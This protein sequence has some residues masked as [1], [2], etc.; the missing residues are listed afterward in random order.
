MKKITFIF[1]LLFLATIGYSQNNQKVLAAPMP[2]AAP[3]PGGGGDR[4]V[5]WYRDSDK[6]GFGDPIRTRLSATKIDGYVAEGD[7]LD[8]TNKYITNVAP[9]QYFYHDSD[10]D[11][12]GNPNVRVFYSIAPPNYVTNNLDC[13]DN[14]AAIKPTTVWYR[15]G[16]HDGYGNRSITIIGCIQ[17]ADYVINPWDYDDANGAITNITPQTF[18]RDYDTDTFGSP[19]VTVY[20]SVKPDGYVTNN[21]DCND[22]NV[23]INPN[24]VW[25]RDVDGDNFGVREITVLS[26]TRP[27]GYTDNGDDCNDSDY[28]LNPN[29]VWYIDSDHDTFGAGAGSRFGC[30][31]PLN[32]DYVLKGGDCND[33][34][35]NV[36]PDVMWY[37]DVD[38]DG[39]GVTNN[40]VKSCTQPVGYARESG[41]CDDGNR[42]IKPNTIWYFDN[43]G[44]GHGAASQTKQSCT[45]PDRYVDTADDCNDYDV[46]VYTV[47]VWYY[48]NDGDTFGDPAVTVSSCNKPYKYVL[49][50]AD[51]DDRTGNITNIPPRTFYEDYDKDTFGNPNVSVYY[52]NQPTGYVT[53]ASDYDDRTGNIIN[54]QP[55]NFYEDYDKDTFGNPNVSLYYSLQPTGYVTNASDYNDRN[56]FITNIPPQTF[57]KDFDKDTFGNPNITLYYSIQPTGYVANNTDCDD[58]NGDLNPNTK[59]Y[60]DNEQDGLG[61][62]S[63]FVQ[64]CTPPAGKYVANYSDNCPTIAGTSPDC[65]SLASP[66]SDYNYI[67]TTTYKEPTNTILQGPTPEKALVNITYFDG[68]GRPVQQIANKQSTAGKDIITSTGYDDFGRPTKEYLPYAANSSNMAY[69]AN[70][71]ENA[72]TFYSAEKYENTANPFSEKK[73]ELSP[74]GRVIKQAAPGNDWAMDGGHEIKM[75]YQTNTDTEVKLYRA[76]ANWNAGSGLFD[77]AL[78]EDGNY[79]A[80]ELIKTVTYDENSSANPTENGGSTVEFKNKEGKVILKR[81]YESGT[82]HDTHY[83]YDTYGNLTYVIPPKADG[84]INQEVLDGLC[85]QYKYDYRNRLVEKKIPGKQWEFIVYDK[86]DRPVA[87]G[88][89]NSPFKDDTAV[90]WLITKYDAF[91]RPVYTG[92]SNSTA[93][94]LSRT[95]LQNAQNNATVLFETKQ[96][97]GAIDGI[98]AY[99]SNT[100][101]PTSIK[102]L[103]VNYYDNYTFPNVPT[104]PT[105]IEGQTVL[106]N[107]KGLATGS[108][109]RVLTTASTSLGETSTTFYDAKAR[110][111]RSYVQNYLDG[112]TSTD[113][114]LDFSGQLLY[115]IAKHKRTTGDVE[116]VTKEDF[117]YSPQGRILTH[118]HQINGGAIQLLAANTYDDLGQLSSKKVGN[119]S[120][121]PLQKIDYTYNIRGW[122]T[123]I[124]NDSSNNLILNTTEKDLFGFKINYNVVAGS[125]ANLKP[126]YNGNIAETFWRSNSDGTLRS[127]GYQ[128]DDLNRLKKAIYQKPG[129]NIP[130]SGAYNESLSYDKNGNITS[131][132][133]FGGSD[134]PSII[135]QID[136]LAYDYSNANSNQL[137]KVTDS[138]AGNDS[139]GFIDGNKTGDDYSYDS[140]GNM[141]T[142]KNKNITNI[143][144]NHLNLPVKITFGTGNTIAYIY[145]SAG[146]KVQKTVN[147]LLPTPTVTTTN[148]LGGFQYKDNVLQFFPTAEGYV[149]PNGSSYKYVFQYKDHLGNVRLSYGDANGDGAITNSE[150]I[151]ESHYYPFGLKHQGYNSTVTSTNPAQKRLFGGKELQDELGLNM[152]DYGARLY[153]PADCTWWGIDPLAEK[154]SSLS[155]YAYVANNPTNAI[156]PDGRDIIFIVTKGDQ[157]R[158]FQYRKGNFYELDAN[159]KYSRRYNPGKE[160][161][162]PTMYKVLSTYRKIEKSNDSRLKGV[163]HKLETSKLHHY[164][165]TGYKSAVSAYGIPSTSDKNSPVGT[166]TSYHF[167]KEDDAEYEKTEGTTDSD[168]AAVAHEM[169]HQ[170]DYD[171]GNMADDTENNEKDPS[172][173]RAVFFENLMRKTLKQLERTQYGKPIDP[174]DLKEPP[175]NKFK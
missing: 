154:F 11:T 63:N 69:D 111:I 26:C 148:Y 18:Y 13:N 104:I 93:D 22:G 86:L 58:S 124:N 127:Y 107:A 75:D 84:T 143:V 138:P 17:P 167:S 23:A 82:K 77:I 31:P 151:E 87:T 98:Q 117:T 140:N 166:R 57:Y 164:V 149:E 4:P 74:L 123:G 60:A 136:D 171:I 162:D 3:P 76:A 173:I 40:F 102:L 8:D 16:D 131:L 28:D 160:S 91:G 21:L 64:Q 145:N 125:V 81:T 68:L 14:N 50:N 168:D 61:D 92:W 78:S 9:T 153:D 88:P 132:Q 39:F 10:G 150:I 46:T 126:L 156:D 137:T 89:A 142:D 152:Y 47:R 1:F 108:W 41:D 96:T 100:V 7:D 128:Y 52:S 97:S 109:T 105:T 161:V 80:S 44:D 27:A 53:N 122:M 157:A 72:I 2:M 67:I 144:Y 48:D 62:P 49:N 118:T 116:L 6:D 73:L 54:I 43:D 101:A 79:A 163:L 130:V 55:R 34:N 66:S 38:G 175:S 147:S 99:Y 71:A 155:P 15:D 120:G 113:S 169:R 5:T 129:E 172:E 121:T 12:F 165:E 170:F 37:R 115:T 141:I 103:T 119:N 30:A 24:T 32:H 42:F 83:V 25:Y 29:T 94:A 174:K 56:E 159:G 139:Q 35:V 70:A 90:G 95:T 45:K 146:L 20:C 112:Y 134:A 51:Y 135:F 33:S 158:N 19:T 106:A 114:K 85:Y 36:H 59:W 65:S 133:R 110:P